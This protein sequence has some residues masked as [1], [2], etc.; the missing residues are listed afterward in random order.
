MPHLYNVGVDYLIVG[1]LILQIW[2]P[3]IWNLKEID[4]LHSTV[5]ETILIS[6]FELFIIVFFRFSHICLIYFLRR[7]FWPKVCLEVAKLWVFEDKGW[8]WLWRFH[9]YTNL[10]W[11]TAD[12]GFEEFWTWLWITHY[13]KEKTLMW[14]T[15]L[16]RN[17][18]ESVFFD[19]LGELD[20]AN[21]VR[22]SSNFAG[23]FSNKLTIRYKWRFWK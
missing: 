19:N 2:Y 22:W 12:L 3:Q 16:L 7:L 15:L 5:R 9:K 11:R 23:W 10:K 14:K 4:I 17:Q 8:I 20:Q 6:Q 13:S 1:T 18:T 21:Y